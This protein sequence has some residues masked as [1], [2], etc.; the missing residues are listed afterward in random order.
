MQY[1]KLILF[2]IIYSQ[3]FNAYQN[4]LSRLYEYCKNDPYFSRYK[5]YR[6]TEDQLINDKVIAHIKEHEHYYLSLIE[7]YISKREYMGPKAKLDA[8]ISKLGWSIGQ[9]LA[10]L[11]WL[12][13][14]NQLSDQ[15]GHYKM[16]LAVT[17]TLATSN[18]LWKLWKG[19]FYKKRMKRKL[20][21]DK[22]VRRHLREI[23]EI[24]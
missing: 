15:L 22:L 1:A 8:Q 16:P 21:R 17:A 20:E 5:L 13:T 23:T 6:M 3:H 7:T 12:T 11:Y 2:M 19:I 24:I 10:G 9:I 14:V 18:G 4:P